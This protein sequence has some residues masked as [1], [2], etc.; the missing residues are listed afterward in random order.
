MRSLGAGVRVDAMSLAPLGW[1]FVASCLVAHA[2]G[3]VALAPLPLRPLARRPGLATEALDQRADRDRQQIVFARIEFAA[4][5]EGHDLT[6]ERARRAEASPLAVYE[7]IDAAKVRL[8]GG[9]AL[10][11]PA[12]GQGDGASVLLEGHALFDSAGDDRETDRDG[13]GWHRLAVD[14]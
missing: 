1:W 12:G 5:I 4:A 8:G 7:K 13:G 14:L 11:L 2:F 3:V 10:D 6:A 9:H